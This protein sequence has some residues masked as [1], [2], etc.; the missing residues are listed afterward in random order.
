MTATL[1]IN[2]LM[3]FN[4]ESVQLM[5]QTLFG[6]SFIAKIVLPLSTHA[7]ITVVK[8]QKLQ[9]SYREQTIVSLADWVFASILKASSTQMHPSNLILFLSRTVRTA[10][11][12]MSFSY[13]MVRIG[14]TSH[15]DYELRHLQD[16]NAEILFGF[17]S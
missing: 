6:W 15:K 11:S 3:H 7:T 13:L 16:D 5:L 14:D 8:P 1:M 17:D 4:I 10:C 9:T 12:S 2:R